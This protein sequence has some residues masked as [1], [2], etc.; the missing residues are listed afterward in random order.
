[1]IEDIIDPPGD[2][3]DLSIRRTHVMN[4]NMIIMFPFSII[5]GFS[6]PQ[7]RWF[8]PCHFGYEP[9]RCHH[10]WRPSITLL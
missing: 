10:F 5:L 4:V 2:T 8:V 9:N 1:M 3:R 7:K 6:G